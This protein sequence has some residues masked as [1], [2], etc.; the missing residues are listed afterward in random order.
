MLEPLRSLWR[1]FRQPVSGLSH[2][3]A[4]LLSAVGLVWLL[5]L[6]AASG[7]E[8]RLAPLAIFGG[9]MVLLFTASALY[10]LLPVSERSVA[11]LRKLDHSA[12]FVFIAGS[13]TPVCLLVLQGKKGLLL[14]VAIWA[15]ALLGVLM[16][17]V[18]VGTSRWLRV[19]P[20]LLMGWMALLA[21]PDLWAKLPGAGFAWLAAEGLIYSLG[22][23]VYAAKW[24]DPLPERFGFHEVWH[25][26]VIGG[27]FCHFWLVAQYVLPA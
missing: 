11:R 25:L 27:S 3:A 17:L 16:K 5:R 4:A 12:I 6:V 23:V 19:G 15:A 8:A 22:A 14:T 10:H 1:W 13:Y 20:Y 21:L 18:S 26:F 2:L 9:S 7:A 24:P